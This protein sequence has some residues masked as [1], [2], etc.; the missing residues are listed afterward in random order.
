MVLA[1]GKVM[2][3]VA[4]KDMATAKAF[5][6]G[7]LG[8]KQVDENAGGVAYVSGGGSLF[9]YGSPSA[10]SGQSTAA[11][12]LVDDI[13]TAVSELKEK[14]IVFESYDMPGATKDGDVHVMGSM[15]AAWFKDPDGNIL[16]LAN[17]Q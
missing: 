12:W 8:L 13:E 5:Y 17:G 14:G 4:V 16:G 9:V 1:N 10:G 2:A 7:T 15:K 3:M 6:G 11:T